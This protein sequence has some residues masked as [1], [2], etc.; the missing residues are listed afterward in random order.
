MSEAVNL[1]EREARC[2]G[3]RIAMQ[4]LVDSDR[5]LDWEDYPMLGEF[6]FQRLDEAVRSE[7]AAVLRDE[8][9]HNEQVWDIDSALLL[10]RVTA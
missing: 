1:N 4:H 3:L 6:A 2:L 7:I 8:L 9:R 10:E 5:W